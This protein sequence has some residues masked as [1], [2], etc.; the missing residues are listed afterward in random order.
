[1]DE[2]ITGILQVPAHK[3]ALLRAQSRG[4]DDVYR[5]ALAEY[6]LTNYY[7]ASWE[8]LGGWLLYYQEN[9]ALKILKRHI[10]HEEGVSMCS[11]FFVPPSLA[12]TVDPR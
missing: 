7:S 2:I 10:N 1:M 8:D 9:A 5:A 12:C 11:A 4:R 3:H 6:Y